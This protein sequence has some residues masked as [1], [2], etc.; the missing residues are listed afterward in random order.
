MMLKASLDSLFYSPKL[1]VWVLC[2]RGVVISS[3][4]LR[5]HFA[6]VAQWIEHPVSTRSVAGSTPVRSTK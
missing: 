6:P 4:A 2:V 3:A 5:T 1:C